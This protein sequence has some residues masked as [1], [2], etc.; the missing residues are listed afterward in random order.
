MGFLASS[1]YSFLTHIPTIYLIIASTIWEDSLILYA[2]TI[3][4]S[5]ESTRTNHFTC[6]FPYNFRKLA[7]LH[8]ATYFFRN[9][10]IHVTES[11]SRCTKALLSFAFYRYVV[12]AYWLLLTLHTMFGNSLSSDANVTAPSPSL[13]TAI[14][15][16]LDMLSG[17]CAP[18]WL[19]IV[20]VLF[21]TFFIFRYFL[22]LL[23]SSPSPS[24]SSSLSPSSKS[25]TLSVTQ[26]LP[27]HPSPSCQSFEKPSMSIP[28]LLTRF[29]NIR[30]S[31]QSMLIYAKNLLWD[32]FLY[33][34]LA[35]LINLISVFLALVFALLQ[36][37][38]D[39]LYRHNHVKVCVSSP[40]NSPDPS[41]TL[42]SSSVV[43]PL[44][45]ATLQPLVEATHLSKRKTNASFSPYF[46]A[47]MLP[48]AATSSRPRKSLILDLDET[49]V[50]SQLHSND[51][52]DIRLEIRVDN[53]P[54][55]FYVSKR[56]HLDVFLRTVAQWYN[57]VIF[58]ASLQ[59]YADPL[60]TVLDVNRVIKRRIFRQHCIK[61]NGNFIKDIT[62]V[63]PN[64]ADVLIVDNSPAAYS[65]HP[66]NAI[67]IDTWYSDQ[68]DEEL[69]NLLPLLHALAFLNDVRSVLDLRL[70]GGTLLAR[71]NYLNHPQTHHAHSS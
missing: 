6:C 59:K 42:P 24:L 12:T 58:T 25:S 26:A 7:H 1:P 71:K 44:S 51:Y 13:K 40:P 48:S 46:S 33:P 18:L 30:F 27:A 38:H 36:S 15:Q 68:S 19:P 11:L 52:C 54:A 65:M 63:N 5:F 62:I 29:Y 45:S 57:V 3:V 60:I 32:A 39:A 2:H 67:P 4:T 14:N 23:K 17:Q 55:V 56:P 35:W 41:A 61:R 20:T 49:L 66:S 34:I 64:L 10:C 9:R 47:L 31:L 43:N 28:P 53:Y 22:R 37:T 8:Q 69:L 21:L 50:H 16:L 70:T